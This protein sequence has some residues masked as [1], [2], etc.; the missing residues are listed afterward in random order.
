MDSRE[1]GEHIV[2]RYDEELEELRAKVLRIGGLVESQLQQALESVANQDGDQA[3]RV[4][5]ADAQVNALELEID[6]LCC[7]L[8]ARRSPVAGDLRLVISVIKTVTDLERMGD[9][10]VRIARMAMRMAARGA[11]PARVGELRHL[12]PRVQAMLR[13]ALDTFARMDPASAAQVMEQD[14]AVDREY[15]SLSR[16]TITFMMEDPRSIPRGLDLMFAARALERLGDRAC[17]I[18]EHVIFTVRGQDV[19][20]TSIDKVKDT[21]GCG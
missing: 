11:A 13:D 21:A 19:R 5:S 6:G 17:N 9:E 18:C 2:H 7:Q 8:L 10:S 20:H 14:R 12:G 1:L 16:E 4:V 15:E 3:A